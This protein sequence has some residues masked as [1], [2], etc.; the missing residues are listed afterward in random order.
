MERGDDDVNEPLSPKEK[1]DKKKHRHHH[2]DRNADGTER[3]HRHRDKTGRRKR[4]KAYIT[5]EPALPEPKSK[6]WDVVGLWRVILG[7]AMVALMSGTPNAISTIS[8]VSFWR[9]GGGDSVLR[10]QGWCVNGLPMGTVAE[11]A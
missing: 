1:K 5:V 6:F 4:N 8:G 11:P 2:R 3:A 10:V 9:A 7:A